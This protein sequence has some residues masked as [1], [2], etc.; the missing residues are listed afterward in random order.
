[1]DYTLASPE[2]PGALFIEL[3]MIGRCYRSRGLGAAVVSWLLGEFS[4]QVNRIQAGV[5]V[6]NPAA[7]RFWQ[8]MGFR[9]TGPAQT[10]P[11]TTT[12]YPLEWAGPQVHPSAYRDGK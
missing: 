8:C 1:L 3:L 10:F 7:I 6:N 5:Q 12:A 9:I 11:D 2:H 4:G